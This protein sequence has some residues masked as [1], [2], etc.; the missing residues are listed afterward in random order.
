MR[1][2]RNGRGGWLVGSLTVLASAALIGC[3]TSQRES[4]Y[5]VRERTHRPVERT[6]VLDEQEPRTFADA[7]QGQE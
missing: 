3:S 7:W 6:I 5:E 1:Q 2:L 4:F